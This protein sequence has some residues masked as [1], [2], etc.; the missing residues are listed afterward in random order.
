MPI[1]HT[2]T[3]VELTDK[4]YL[5]IGKLVIEFSNL[6]FLLAKLLSRLLIIPEFL[7][8][9]Y[10]DQMTAEKIIDAIENAL[11]VHNRRYSNKIVTERQVQDIKE[12]MSEIRG[13]KTLRNKFAHYCWSRLDDNKIFGTRLSG[14][15]PTIKKPNK[16]SI[17]ITN[18]ALKKEYRKAYSAVEKLIEIIDK[19]PELEENKELLSKVTKKQ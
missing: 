9:T 11:D 16:Y 1:N 17:T 10:A 2:S 15:I 14:A 8:R 18:E 19:L 5:L 6:E 4:Q 3:Y 12:L 7:G 13:V